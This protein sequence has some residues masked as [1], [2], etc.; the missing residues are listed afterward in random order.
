MRGAAMASL[1]IWCGGATDRWPLDGGR[2]VVGSGE[3]VDLRL[4]DPTVST[5]HCELERYGAVWLVRDLA[6]RNGTL[7]NGVRIAG[8]HRLRDGDVVMVGETRLS[9]AAHAVSGPTTR[10]LDALPELT[11]SERAV[12]VEL[13]RPMLSGNAFTPPATTNEISRRRHTSSGATKQHLAR[14][15][16][17]FDVPEA[18]TGARD[19]RRVALANQAVRRGAVTERDLLTEPE[20]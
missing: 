11:K 8:G 12:L 9:Y 14:L 10:P 7:V 17:K 15:Y 2:C 16:D 19:E 20:D 13:C 1:E 18:T 5:V 3:E 4:G 6:S